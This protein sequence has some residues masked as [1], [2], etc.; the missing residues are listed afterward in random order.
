[1]DTTRALAARVASSDFSALPADTR[2][3]AKQALL[4]FLGVTLAGTDEPLSRILK[5]EA[6]DDGGAPQAQIFGSSDRGSVNPRPTTAPPIAIP[7]AAISSSHW[8]TATP[9]SG[10]DSRNSLS[11]LCAKALPFRGRAYPA[12]LTRSIA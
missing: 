3:V 8:T 11:L 5:D 7:I 2:E 4:D 6:R 1:M 12:F 9:L 10:C